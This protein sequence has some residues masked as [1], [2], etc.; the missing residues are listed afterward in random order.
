MCVSWWQG[1]F[2][3]MHGLGWT[4]GLPPGS[5]WL[6][7]IRC[8]GLLWRVW[9]GLGG[10]ATCDL[11]GLGASFHAEMAAFATLQCTNTNTHVGWPDI[12]KHPLPACNAQAMSRSASF[13][14]FLWFRALELLLQQ[15]PPSSAPHTGQHR[16][17]SGDRPHACALPNPGCMHGLC[18]PGPRELARHHACACIVMATGARQSRQ[19]CSAGPATRHARAACVQEQTEAKGFEVDEGAVPAVP[20]LYGCRCFM[21]AA[22]AR[23]EV[24]YF[25]AGRH[26]QLVSMAARDY[27]TLA[28]PH[29]LPFAKELDLHIRYAPGGHMR[30]GA[31][32][33]IPLPCPASSCRPDPVATGAP[34]ALGGASRVAGGLSV[35]HTGI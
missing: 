5:R 21:D 34:A 22:L 27:R 25:S 19:L 14:P 15:E 12:T 32:I 3:L 1:A 18:L 35:M 28:A 2:G 9:G 23:D 13:S 4:V 31:R 6:S 30:V 16:F 10:Q 8:C 33:S 11:G 29:V 24:L 7:M 26:A 17:T 20:Q